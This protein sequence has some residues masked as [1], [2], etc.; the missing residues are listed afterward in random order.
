[1]AN[2]QNLRPPWRAGESG[3]PAGHSQDRR[4]L[5][6]I[7]ASGDFDKWLDL[8]MRMQ[9]RSLQS[10]LRALRVGSDGAVKKAVG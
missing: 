5:A 6:R 2:P 7:D 3:N 8:F 4:E 9:R 1:M 10:R